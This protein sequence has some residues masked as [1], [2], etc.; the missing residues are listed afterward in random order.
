MIRPS[1]NPV[2]MSFGATSEPYSAGSP[3]K[4]V[5]FSY[6]PDDVIYMPDDAVVTLVPNNGRDGNGV[7]FTT[8]NGLQHGLLHTSKYLVNNGVFVRKGQPV[9]V[10]G[11]TGFAQGKHLHWA[12]KKNGA[13]VNGLDYVDENNSDKEL[14]MT[15]EAAAAI[16]DVKKHVER[17]EAQIEDLKANL[18]AQ[19]E[20]IVSFLKMQ[21]SK[22]EDLKKHILGLETQV[23]NLKK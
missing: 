16:D 13:F 17:A 10:M 2:T 20:A 5:D 8:A 3:H 14:S 4:G 23:D 1:Q 18:L 21:D 12:V 6:Q 15:P 9:A 22:S 19:S 7:Y 11:D